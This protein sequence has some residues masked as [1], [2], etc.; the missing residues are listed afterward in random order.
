[1]TYEP[2]EDSVPGGGGT[3]VLNKSADYL[4]LDQTASSATDYRI[5][6]Q[7]RS[8]GNSIVNMANGP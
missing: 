8:E 3:H 2:G 4:N 6:N 7:F 5:S 1:M